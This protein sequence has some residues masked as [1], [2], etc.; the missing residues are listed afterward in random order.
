MTSRSISLSRERSATIFFSRVFSASNASSRG[1]SSGRSPP[2]FFFQL[3]YVAWLIP[4]FRQTSAIGIPASPCFST[5][6]FCASVNLDAFDGIAGTY[7]FGEAGEVLAGP[8][9]VR[10]Y[11]VEGGRWLEEVGDA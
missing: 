4:A 2:Y 11:V 7:R 5:N 3:K 1:I 6:A 9:D 8:M 10:V